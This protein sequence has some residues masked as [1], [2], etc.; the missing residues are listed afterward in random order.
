MTSIANHSI[1]SPVPFVPSL[2]DKCGCG[3]IWAHAVNSQIE[4]RQA[5]ASE[6][7]ITAL[8]TDLQMGSLINSDEKDGDLVSI[9]HGFNHTN[10][11]LLPI[12]AHPPGDESDLSVSAFL[13]IV[14]THNNDISNDVD[15]N[16][17]DCNHSLIR[18]VKFDM[19]EV[20]VVEPTLEILKQGY[21]GSYSVLLN[22]DIIPGPGMRHKPPRIEGDIFMNTIESFLS[23]LSDDNL[24]KKATFLSVGWAVTYKTF[25]K[26]CLSD[27][28]EMYTLLNR[29]NLENTGK[30]YS[31]NMLINLFLMCSN[32]EYCLCN[33]NRNSSERTIGCKKYGSV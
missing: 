14:N 30:I 22:A 24:L 20:A 5:L 7:E 23:G 10:G 17:G 8:E 2:G 15:E 6:S 29:Y 31:Y 32:N 3:P 27:I 19:K 11:V 12:D 16:N 13:N 21:G 33:R 28:D 26:Y 9:L 25:D 1:A 4:L 18:T